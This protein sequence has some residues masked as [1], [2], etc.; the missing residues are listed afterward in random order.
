[1]TTLAIGSV[2]LGT[3]LGRFFKCWVLVPTS[4]F[5][6]A[7]VFAG[8]AYYE[9]GLLNALLEFAVIATCLQIGYLVRPSFTRH[10][11]RVATPQGTPRNTREPSHPA[12]TR[13]QQLF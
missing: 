5:T 9:Y 10:P 11:R 2:L 1:V 8:S 13:Q 3:V 7:I 6:F 4:A 12:A